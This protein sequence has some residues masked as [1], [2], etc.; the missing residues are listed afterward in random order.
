MKVIRA[1]ADGSSTVQPIAEAATEL[2]NG[3]APNVKISVGGIGTGDGFKRFCRG[4]LQIADASRPLQKDD[5]ADKC[6]SGEVKAVQVQVGIDGLSIVANKDLAIP[7]DCITTANLKK[8][9]DPNERKR[10]E[11]ARETADA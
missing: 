6:K 7:D 10:D 9:L 5:V 2:F 11:R 8:L 4:E 3:E 1:P